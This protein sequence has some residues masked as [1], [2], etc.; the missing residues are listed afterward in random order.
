MGER[1]GEGLGAVI[2]EVEPG[3]IAAGLGLAPGDRILRLNGRRLTDLIRLRWEWAG[4]DV[5]LEAEA[6]G[7]VKTFPI[8]KEYDAGLGVRFETP[9][10]DGVRRCGNRCRFCFVDQMPPGCR[11]SLYVK[12]DDFRLSFLQG[13]FVTLTNLGAGDWRRIERERLSPLYVSVHATDPVVRGQLLGRPGGDSLMAVLRRLDRAGIEFH[14]QVVLCP[15]D[16]DGPVLERTA[17]EFGALA[18]SLSLAVVPVGL[19]GWREGLPALRTVSSTQA[20]EII[21][22]AEGRQAEFLAAKGSR[23][24]WLSDEFYCL[25]GRPVPE[26]VTYEDYPQWEN[27][28][29]LIR[30]L[31]DEAAGYAWPARQ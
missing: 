15:G 3:G 25:A 10:F 29:G 22:W 24:L 20:G 28:V 5:L 2:G 23:F 17:A 31:L 12:D 21:D 4:E 13:S 7:A 16:N 11:P 14:G 26:A 8:K 18:G 6:G 9:V 19:T 1:E 30:G 27:G